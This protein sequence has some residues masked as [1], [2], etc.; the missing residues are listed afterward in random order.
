MRKPGIKD[1]SERLS[2]PA[3]FT[4]ISLQLE[5]QLPSRSN[6]AFMFDPLLQDRDNDKEKERQKENDEKDTSGRERES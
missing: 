1:L 5:L 2:S 4:L 6:T 3:A